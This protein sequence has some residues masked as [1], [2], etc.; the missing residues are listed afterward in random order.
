MFFPFDPHQAGLD[1]RQDATHSTSAMQRPDDT[2]V[3]HQVTTKGSYA[4]LLM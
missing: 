4:S 1:L 3:A 2:S